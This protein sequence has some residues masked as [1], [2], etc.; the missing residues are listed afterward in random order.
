MAKKIPQWVKDL[1]TNRPK[2][3][4]VEKAVK[5][6]SQEILA[7]IGEIDQQSSYEIGDPYAIIEEGIPAV[8]VQYLTY[9]HE[10]APE[11]PGVLLQSLLETTAKGLELNT[12]EQFI[13]RGKRAAQAQKDILAYIERQCAASIEA[14]G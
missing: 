13:G 1:D 11:Q 9:Q 12:F 6:M 3:A 10:E 4:E 14:I 7:K 5:G 8:V 2:W